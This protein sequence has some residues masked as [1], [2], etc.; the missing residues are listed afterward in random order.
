MGPLGGVK[1][2]VERRVARF[3]RLMATGRRLFQH[4]GWV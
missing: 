2:S 1:K 4:S 3:P